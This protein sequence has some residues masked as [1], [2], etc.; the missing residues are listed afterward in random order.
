MLTVVQ[1]FKK[2]SLFNKSKKQT[3]IIYI[4]KKKITK[5]QQP[6]FSPLDFR[7]FL[8]SISAFERSPFWQQYI[9]FL[10]TL[11]INTLNIYV[12]DLLIITKLVFS[13]HRRKR[14][15]PT[16]HCRVDKIRIFPQSFLI[17]LKVLSIL[18]IFFFHF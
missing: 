15:Q 14:P 12:N 10:S 13:V 16:S 3:N 8:F 17:F 9:M 6:T 2:F 7:L 18:L 1:R 11:L 5:S 4:T